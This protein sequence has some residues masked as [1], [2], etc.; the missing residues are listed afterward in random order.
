MV[1]KDYLR[2]VVLVMP[3]TE[4]Y[5]KY[6]KARRLHGTSL[7][8]DEKGNVIVERWVT[9][10]SAKFATLYLD[11]TEWVIIHPKMVKDPRAYLENPPRD[12]RHIAVKQFQVCES[13]LEAAIRMVG[14]HIR[15]PYLPEVG[16][17]AQQMEGVIAQI[18]QLLLR[19]SEYAT[20]TEAEL[21]ALKAKTIEVILALGFEASVH[22]LK[23]WVATRAL[24]ASGLKDARGRRNL[25]VSLT[26]L[27]SA[28][29][30]ALRRRTAF[31]EWYIP[32]YH[33]A[34]QALLVERRATR[35]AFE[36]TAKA[37]RSILGH[38]NFR[39][40]TASLKGQNKIVA[41]LLREL[42]KGPIA[43]TKLRPYLGIAK[44]VQNLLRQAADIVE[45]GNFLAAKGVLLEAVKCLKD[46]LEETEEIGYEEAA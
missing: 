2:S 18:R 15:T 27:L 19:F 29:L 35:W 36:D 37:I 11:E 9:V 30:W 22:P 32:K 45:S 34:Y 39:D 43:E 14:L 6:R 10:S 33:L 41:R 8:Y 24:A 5:R 40:P 25:L 21:E 42:A 7:R 28:L 46:C 1:G 16:A 31:G 17:E 3:D 44:V 20:L 38:I 4:E 26:R 12:R 13:G 23:R